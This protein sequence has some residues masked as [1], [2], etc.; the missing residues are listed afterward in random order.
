MGTPDFSIPSLRMLKDEKWNLVAIVT[1][2]DRPRNR[3]KKIVYSPV[4]QFA[5]E[6]NIELLQPNKM[7]DEDFINRLKELKPCLFITAAF[8]RILTK[9]I[10]DIPKYG[11]I[12]VHASLLPKY[13]GAAPIHRALINGEK[14]TGVTTMMTDIGLDTG[15]ILIKGK[16][17]ITETI[18]VGELHDK[19]AQLGANILKETID[20]LDSGQLN[21]IKQI[22]EDATYAQIIDKN[23]GC[24]NWDDTSENICNLV[25]GTS[26]WPGAY[27]KYKGDKMKIWKVEKYNDSIKKSEPGVICDVDKDGILVS[28]KDGVV[29]IREVQFSSCRRMCVSEYICGH[30]IDKGEKLG[31]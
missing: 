8:G 10:L 16:V 21:P 20:K 2:P 15:D 13:R 31:K 5:I 6:N 24:I 19:L 17:E 26:P 25:R 7:K 30:K 1:Q 29:R 22:N 18:T 28:T 3:G 27:T 4:K 11:C 14:E 9:E 12:N 23:L